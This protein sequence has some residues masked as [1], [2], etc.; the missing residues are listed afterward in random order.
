MISY[1]LALCYVMIH[2]K[3]DI[4]H[5]CMYI[6]LCAYTNIHTRT[7]KYTY[8]H[9]LVFEIATVFS[10]KNSH[11]ML[12]GVRTQ[13]HSCMYE[14]VRRVSVSRALRSVRCCVYINHNE[15]LTVMVTRVS[16]HRSPDE[17]KR[18]SESSFRHRSRGGM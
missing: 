15:G 16:S 14:E 7:Y 3:P 9:T 6:Y 10:C 18:L 5:T 8:T 12:C 13:V 2:M 11:R 17:F 4:L 1:E